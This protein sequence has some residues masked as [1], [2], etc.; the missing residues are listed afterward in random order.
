VYGYLAG[1][2]R[3]VRPEGLFF[4]FFGR[5][6]CFLGRFFDM[7]KISLRDQYQEQGKFHQ[8]CYC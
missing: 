7:L 2:L 1:T 5:R 6:L 4:F 8:F 3:L